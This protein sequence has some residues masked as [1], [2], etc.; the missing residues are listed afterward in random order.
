MQTRVPWNE[1][2]E[3]AAQVPTRLVAKYIPDP[4]YLGWHNW[5]LFRYPP[6]RQRRYS[7]TPAWIAAGPAL[8]RRSCSVVLLLCSC[9]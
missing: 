2:V 9:A 1:S 5:W 7:G 3:K 6:C 8:R 4:G